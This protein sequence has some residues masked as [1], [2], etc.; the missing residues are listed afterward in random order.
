MFCGC[1][2]FFFSSPPFSYHFSSFFFSVLFL[3]KQTWHSSVVSAPCYSNLTHNPPNLPPSQGFLFLCLLVI[4]L[5][6]GAFWGVS[7][8][9]WFGPQAQS[10]TD[11]HG[12]FGSV[13]WKL[14]LQSLLNPSVANCKADPGDSL[15]EPPV[16]IIVLQEVFVLFLWFLWLFWFFKIFFNDFHSLTWVTLEGWGGNGKN[17]DSPN[18]F[19]SLSHRKC[20]YWWNG[21]GFW[22]MSSPVERGGVEVEDKWAGKG[23]GFFFIKRQFIT[24][25]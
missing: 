23:L 1:C 8:L 13:L 7:V 17:I 22:G 11:G 25:F 20:L 3:L 19:H 9:P 18:L 2:V 5:S 15:R 21:S 10:A 16:Q 24:E 4:T 6:W 12:L 14:N